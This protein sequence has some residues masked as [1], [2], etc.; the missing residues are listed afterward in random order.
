MDEVLGRIIEAEREARRII[1]SAYEEAKRLEA[2]ARVRAE[3]QA[4]IVYNEVI[5]RAMREAEEEVRRIEEDTKREIE[6]IEEGLLTEIRKLERLVSK[7]FEKA[8]NLLLIE[9]LRP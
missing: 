4:K 2:E 7:N 9:V 3:E 1:D 8:V 6:R 5:Q